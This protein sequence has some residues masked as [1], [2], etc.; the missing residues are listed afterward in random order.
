M[1]SL[2][3]LDTPTW[4]ILLAIFVSTLAASEAGFRVGRRTEF[5]AS[6]DAP[7][8]IVQSAALALVALL[9]SLLFTMALGRY[10][11]RRALVVHEANAIGTTVLRARTLAPKLSI[12]LRH[13]LAAYAAARLEF[14][15][16]DADAPRRKRAA[17][18]SDAI[19]ERMW[20]AASN[21][22]RDDPRSTVI[23]LFLETLN[24]TIDLSAEHAAS[25]RYVIPV[26]V[27]AVVTAIVL[28]T[29]FLTGFGFGRRASRG[30][31]P[32]VTLA[33]I[34]ALAMAT[35]VDLDRPQR[36]TIHVDLTP[37]RDAAQS[38]ARAASL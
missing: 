23:P 37:L 30:T 2:I 25:L 1:V 16:A 8:G 11:E 9:L 5:D 34:L 33:L 7:I 20:Q 17:D 15:L 32:N 21:A 28:A 12:P 14:A 31:I 24:E 18:S 22:A 3:M 35:L 26:G 38:A 19:A 29:S 36:G 10:H 6:L 27:V 4:V 13:D